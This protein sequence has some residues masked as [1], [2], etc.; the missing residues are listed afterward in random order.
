MGWIG[1][2]TVLK[3]AL[4]A[5]MLALAVGDAAQAGDLGERSLFRHRSEGVIQ[6]RT[7]TSRHGGW[8]S[9]RRRVSLGERSFARQRQFSRRD[10][11]HPRSVIG[12]FRQERRWRDD[13]G[14][15]Y[16]GGLSAWYEP[17]NGLYLRRYRDEDGYY[18]PDTYRSVPRSRPKIIHVR[19]GRD[20]TACAWE[21][22]V[23]VIRR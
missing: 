11:V 6:S 21:S 16:G 4:V 3:T 13:R 8:Q 18:N 20:Q 10:R 22:G 19:P 5:A 9:D 15:Y 7:T 2:G 1:F 17:G 14:S 12:E 23:C